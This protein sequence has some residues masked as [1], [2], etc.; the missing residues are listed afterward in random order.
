MAVSP[1]LG[2]VLE[3]LGAGQHLRG[4]P[5][6]ERRSCTNRGLVRRR[7]RLDSGGDDADAT[8]SARLRLSS[9]DD[10]NVLINGRQERH[11][12]FDGK[13]RELIPPKCRHLR[14]PDAQ[15]LSGF[16]LR[17][18]PLIQHLIE[19]IGQ[20]EFRLT[21]DRIRETQIGEDVSRATN[22]LVALISLS[23][24][25]CGGM[26]EVYEAEHLGHG[27]RVALKILNE[28]LRRRDDRARLLEEGRLAASIKHPNSVYI[29]GSEEC[30]GNPVITTDLLPGGTLKDR[31]KAGEPTRSAFERPVPGLGRN[32]YTSP[33]DS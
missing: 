10:L 26:G 4:A 5:N 20:S 11:Q 16:G 1:C 13:A 22:D 12:P 9:N 21:L 2:F 27:R 15:H 24:F 30:V 19:R 29:F 28:R 32:R 23:V 3:F 33:E 31:V 18:L 8:R 6:L 17:Q 14:L 7:E 25:G